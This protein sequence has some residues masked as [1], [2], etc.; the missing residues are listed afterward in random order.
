M[1]TAPEPMAYIA[2]APCG[3]TK[4]ATVDRPQYA[5]DIAKEIAACA[6]AGYTIEHVTCAYVREHW[7]S[8]C[9]QCKPGKRRRAAPAAQEMMEL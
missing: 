2:V 6:R 5:K 7:L 3:C 1:T 9:E 4:M 8:S